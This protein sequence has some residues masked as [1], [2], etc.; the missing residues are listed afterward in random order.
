MQRQIKELKRKNEELGDHDRKHRGHRTSDHLEAKASK[1]DRSTDKHG[2]RGRRGSSLSSAED[3][4]SKRR[5]DKVRI[6][7]YHFIS[8]LQ[9]MIFYQTR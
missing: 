6:S 5:T 4:V 7:C 8:C 2:R 3:E 9:F 1:R